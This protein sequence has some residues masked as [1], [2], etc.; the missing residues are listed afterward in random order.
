M[1]VTLTFLQ[2]NSSDVWRGAALETRP[3][4]LWN[5]KAWQTLRFSWF[6]IVFFLLIT[7]LTFSQSFL[8]WW[9]SY[10]NKDAKAGQALRFCW[11]SIFLLYLVV[12]DPPCLCNCHLKLPYI[13][14]I[15]N[16]FHMI[17]ISQ[18]LLLPLVVIGPSLHTPPH[19]GLTRKTPTK[20]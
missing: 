12:V 9:M 2:D 17:V 15:K 20:H 6:R 7:F 14:N 16:S 1:C 8:Q 11:L 5:A 3:W 10:W 19:P 18:A 13:P 4:T